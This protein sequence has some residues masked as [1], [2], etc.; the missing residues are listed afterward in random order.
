MPSAVELSAYVA[1]VGVGLLAANLLLGLLMAAG[2]NP[3]RHWPYRPVK[4][5]RLH[6]WTGYIAF[7][8]AL[9]H[10]AILLFSTSP[11]FRV[12]DVLVPVWSPVQPLSNVLGAVALY[13]VVV[14]VATLVLP[15]CAGSAPLALDSLHDVRGSDHLLHPRS[16]RGSD[17]HRQ[18]HRLHR[19]REGVC[20]VV[21]RAV[22]AGHGVA[23]PAPSRSPSRRARASLRGAGTAVAIV[24]TVAPLRRERSIG[25][26]CR[27]GAPA[28]FS[29]RGLSRRS[30]GSVQPAR[31]RKAEGTDARRITSRCARAAATHTGADSS[32]PRPDRSIWSARIHTA[33]AAAMAAIQNSARGHA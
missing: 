1:L 29:R 22:H 10:P 23:H 26:A 24:K 17:R 18:S 33:A 6:N 25:A 16:D 12:I 7:S 2:Y 9:V 4:L 19:R 28:A 30:A 15:A 5:F 11:R 31:R 32:D 27:A 20:R 13:L 21:R 14:V 3:A 8:A